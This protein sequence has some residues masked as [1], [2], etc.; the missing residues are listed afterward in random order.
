MA[1]GEFCAYMVSPPEGEAEAFLARYQVA[2][3]SV[4][5]FMRG[6]NRSMSETQA[7]FAIRSA[8]DAALNGQ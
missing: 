8:C 4:I 1:D 6:A 2:V 5:S 3:Q 7:L